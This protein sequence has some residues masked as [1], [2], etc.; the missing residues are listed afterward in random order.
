VNYVIGKNVIS[1]RHQQNVINK[2]D[3]GDRLN[4]LAFKPIA[5]RV[6]L[7]F[8]A[9]TGFAVKS[10]NGRFVA[11]VDT[12]VMSPRARRCRPCPPRTATPLFA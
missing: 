5:D 1:K 4:V 11:V 7:V 6:V 9:V 8:P 3:I 2:N 12:M 10:R